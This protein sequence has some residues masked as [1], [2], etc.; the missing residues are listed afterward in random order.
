MRFVCPKDVK[1]DAG[2][3]DKFSV[4]EKVGSEA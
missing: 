2:T 1:K 4:L 3:E